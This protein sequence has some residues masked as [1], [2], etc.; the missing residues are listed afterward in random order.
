MVAGGG[1]ANRRAAPFQRPRLGYVEMG[2]MAQV[3]WKFRRIL[4]LGV[5]QKIWM[6]E[7]RERLS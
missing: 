3:G 2:V 6:A 4:D 5:E 7:S 1:S